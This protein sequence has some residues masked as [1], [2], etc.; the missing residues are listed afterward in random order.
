MSIEQK[1]D[2]LK[3]VYIGA[4]WSKKVDSMPDAQVHAM[5]MRLLNSG[6]LKGF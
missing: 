3:K 4:N 2:I 5:Y 1:R 6:K